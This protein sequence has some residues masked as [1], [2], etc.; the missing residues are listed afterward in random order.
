ML[1]AL[2]DPEAYK[3]EIWTRVQRVIIDAPE[4]V[5]VH[6]IKGDIKQTLTDLLDEEQFDDEGPEPLFDT[7]AFEELPVGSLREHF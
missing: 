4:Q 6:K 3:N 2:E 1:T 7:D 5:E